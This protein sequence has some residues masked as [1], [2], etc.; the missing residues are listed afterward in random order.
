M[1]GVAVTKMHGARNDFVVLDRRAH[2]VEDLPALARTLCDRHT[3]IGA[4]GLL[5]IDELPNGSLSMRIINADGSEAEMCGNGIRCVAAYL[6]AS[7]EGAQHVIATIAGPIATQVVERGETYQVRVA[8]GVPKVDGTIVDVGNPHMV[9]FANALDDVDLE[10]QAREYTKH[11][12]DG[13]NVH[14]V[15]LCGPHELRV[16]HY[17][18]GAG[19]TMACGTGAVA[20]AAA[21]IVRGDVSSPVTVHVPGGELRIEWDGRGEAFMTGP[22]VRVFDAEID[23]RALEHAR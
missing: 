5:V 11:H 17:E 2:P 9:I 16:R 8:M 6:D 20:S 10:K 4:D 18:R 14:V 21:A 22:A 7:G 19:Y 12:P 15:V 13:I 3:G 1:P 23:V